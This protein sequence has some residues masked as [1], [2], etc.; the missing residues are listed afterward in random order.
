M[1]SRLGEVNLLQLKI[2][3]KRR[4]NTGIGGGTRRRGLW[5][6]MRRVRVLGWAK[7]CRKGGVDGKGKEGDLKDRQGR[8]M[9]GEEKDLVKEEQ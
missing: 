7:H 2:M 6:E 1:V 4:K 3:G 5:V 8:M 9:G